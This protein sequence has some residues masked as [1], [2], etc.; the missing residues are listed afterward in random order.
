MG[1][2]KTFPPV[3]IYSPHWYLNLF[4]VILK[5]PSDENPY[6]CEMRSVIYQQHSITHTQHAKPLGI[7]Q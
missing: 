2:D 5:I 7:T 4:Y 6:H 1:K 3:S